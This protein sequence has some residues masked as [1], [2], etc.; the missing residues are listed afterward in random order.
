M[1]WLA[2]VGSL[3]QSDYRCTQGCVCRGV[4]TVVH[5]V[6]HMQ[7]CMCSDECAG[8]HTQG[9]MHSGAHAGVYAQWCMHGCTCRGAHTGVHMHGYVHRGGHTGVR[10]IYEHEPACVILT[11]FNIFYLFVLWLCYGWKS[12]SRFMNNKGIWFNCLN[13][14]GI[15]LKPLI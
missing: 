5:A 8:V 1:I 2:V 15:C 7:W 4:C 10:M 13:E 6:V 9:Y 12:L 14:M 3:S 11:L